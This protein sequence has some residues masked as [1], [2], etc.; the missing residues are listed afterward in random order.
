MA[1]YIIEP[2]RRT[3]HGHFSRELPPI[4]TI[5]SG[6]TVRFRT[7]D[8]AWGIEPPNDTGE[9]RRKFEPRTRGLDDG[10]ALC[11]PVEIR[12]AKPGMTL[13]V[14]IEEIVPGAYGWTA[15]GGWENGINERLGVEND[16]IFLRWAL[17]I[18]EMVGQDQ[19]GHT[20]PLRPF[21]GVM[22]MPPDE[23]GVHPTAPPRVTG[24]N[25][26]CKELVAGSTL[27][28]PIAVE[29][30][31]FSVGD[32]HGLQADGEVSSTAI[33]CP[34]ERVTLTFRLH[35]ELHIETPRAYTEAGW[36]TFGF[37]KDLDEATIIAVE[38]MLRLIEEKHGIERPVS[39]GLA[40]LLVDMRITQIVNGVRG[41]HAVLPHGAINS[42][43]KDKG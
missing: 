16:Q 32:G 24:G 39:L 19:F 15:A 29:G 33:E 35:E 2:E 38:A 41:V 22:G 25:I 37:D 18:E 12:G 31:L 23:P 43:K 34:M 7:L 5:D 26:D 28:L 40:S 20:V 14:Q 8:A 11:G 6:D 9:P 42:I 17:D 27:Y 10:H 36:I 1:E 13:E 4:L 30:G 3:L 21:M